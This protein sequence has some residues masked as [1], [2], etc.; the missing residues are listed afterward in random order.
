[1]HKV[2][3]GMFCGVLL[4]FPLAGITASSE[5]YR[6]L[7]LFGNVFER[8]HTDYVTEVEDAPRLQARGA[9]RE[10]E[11]VR[12]PCEHRGVPHRRGP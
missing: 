12:R 10:A 11:E 4:A 1:M 7:D 5:T 6:Q 2:F 3:I 9:Q 8:V